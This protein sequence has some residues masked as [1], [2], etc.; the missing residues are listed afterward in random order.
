MGQIQPETRE[1]RLERFRREHPVLYAMRH[2]A[3][4]VLQVM[5]PLLGLGALLV[6]L[7]PQIDLPWVAEIGAFIRSVRVE[8]GTWIPDISLPFP[9]PRELIRSIVNSPMF[10][11]IKPVVGRVK[12]ALPIIIAIFVAIKEIQRHRRKQHG[13][14]TADQAVSAD[15][16]DGR[17]GQAR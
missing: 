7:L 13:Q 9:S 4:A 10:D 5:L 11:T 8:I 14:P 3:L 1:T 15:A 2:V 6:A 16:S 17:E 12:W